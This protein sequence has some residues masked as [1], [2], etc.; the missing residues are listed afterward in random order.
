MI[1]NHDSELIA[2]NDA[3]FLHENNSKE[4]VNTNLYQYYTCINCW[5]TLV[6]AHSE[7]AGKILESEIRNHGLLPVIAWAQQASD[8]LVR[9]IPITNLFSVICRGLSIADALQCLRFPK[10]FSPVS[11]ALALKSLNKF[12]ATNNRMKLINRRCETEHR[13]VTS[14]VAQEARDVFAGYESDDLYIP[15]FSNGAGKDGEHS[16]VEKIDSWQKPC[17]SHRLYPVKADVQTHWSYGREE[18]GRYL[19]TLPV[20]G[21][22]ARFQT[23]PKSYKTYRTIAMEAPTKQSDQQGVRVALERTLDRNVGDAAPI[24]NQGINGI[25]AQAA[26]YSTIDMSAASDSISVWLIGQVLP[27]EIFNDVMFARSYWILYDTSTGDGDLLHMVTTMGTG[28]C[29][30]LETGL[31]LSIARAG[32]RYAALFLDWAY[33]DDLVSAYGDD[34]IVPEWAYETVRDFLTICGFVVNEDKSFTGAT[35]FRESCGYDWYDYDP[36]TSIYW[37]R[38]EIKEN[39]DS[40][41]SLVA[42]QNRVFERGAGLTYF[43]CQTF[44]CRQIARIAP[45]LSVVPLDTFLE[46]NLEG[47]AVISLTARPLESKQYIRYD[48]RY[49]KEKT[50]ADRLLTFDGSKGDGIIYKEDRIYANLLTETLTKVT[51]YDRASYEM[52]LYEEFLRNGPRYDD[53]TSYVLNIS[54]SYMQPSN[55]RKSAKVSVTRV[56]LV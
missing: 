56:R 40:L 37:P 16:L 22:T 41:P 9:D 7:I 6:G 38:R 50:P 53:E 47:R 28:F 21:A 25:R 13:Y 52:Y 15:R 51:P 4:Y 30:A 42:L 19:W 12:K 11:S 27:R 48:I 34:I 3:S 18:F 5:V 23:V 55:T 20:S 1:S 14:L 44:L 35:P 33:S 43:D 45:K 26:G 39:L 17:F 8:Q 54:S 32:V 36:V 49:D 31:F 2:R 29:F 10:R 24:H 46:Y